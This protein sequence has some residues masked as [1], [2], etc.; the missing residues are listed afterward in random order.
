M[1]FDQKRAAIP[2][3]LGFDV[4]LDE[5]PI[6]GGAINIRDRPALPVRF[7]IVRTS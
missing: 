3:V 7:R 1:M 6:S 4:A 5:L 2:Q